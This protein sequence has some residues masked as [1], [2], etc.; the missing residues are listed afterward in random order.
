MPKYSLSILLFL[1][2]LLGKAQTVTQLHTLPKLSIRALEVVNDSTVWFGANRGVFG[3]TQN[4]G[5]TWKI[6]SVKVDSVY[7]QF[8]S[9]AVL[10][11]STVLLLG[12]A[13]PAYLLKTTN[14]GKTWRVVYS[15]TH[16][17]A[18]FDSMIFTKNNNGFAIGDPINGKITLIKTNN[19]GETWQSVDSDKIPAMMEGEACF[20]TSNSN[21]DAHKNM[22]WFVSGGKRSRLFYSTNGGK[23]FLSNDTPL[24]QGETMTGIFSFDFFNERLGCVTGGNYDK[25]DSSIISLALTNN[26][27]KSWTGIKGSKPFFGSCVR[28]KNANQ[29]FITGH[30]G[31]FS[32]N[33]KTKTFSEIKS[34][35]AEVLKFYTLRFSPTGKTMWMAGSDG[36]IAL[37]K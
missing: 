36:R 14:K 5:K 23:S 13:S 18:F 25:T 29:I 17:K 19:A 28:F 3:F 9:I 35:S 27:G 2:L 8:R 37:V 4:G 1:T 31:T 12:I 26:G 7:P 21:L 6:D 15:N 22:L 11:D 34:E 16:P 24:P 10:N 32:Y 33:I 20:A 30:D